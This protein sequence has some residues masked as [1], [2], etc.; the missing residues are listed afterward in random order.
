M[1][2]AA[3]LTLLCVLGVLSSCAPPPITEGVPSPDYDYSAVVAAMV[4]LHVDANAKFPE[5]FATDDPSRLGTEFDPNT[6]FKV[7]GHLSMDDGFVLDYVYDY[8]GGNGFPLLYARSASAGRYSTCKEYER[9]LG[10][11]DAVWE[12][13]EAYL[14]HLRTDGSPEGF[15]E[16]AVLH[17]LG[18]E[19]YLAWHGG[20]R[21]TRVV[22]TPDDVL[23]IVIGHDTRDFGRAFTRAE[24]RAAFRMDVQPRIQFVGRREV[25][26]SIVT[27]GNWRGF[28]RSTYRFRRAFPHWTAE[29]HVETLVDYSCG[30]RY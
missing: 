23:D 19:F 20:Y 8:E 29:P 26:V 15:F 7:L 22:V 3:A 28:T 1:K 11:T 27:F 17:E 24:K 10:G 16:L 21:W 14:E 2:R 25:I 12:A 4:N 13:E 30:I 9:A 18:G 5:H 6:Y